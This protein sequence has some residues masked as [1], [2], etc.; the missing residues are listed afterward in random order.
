MLV[1]IYIYTKIYIYRYIC[2]DTGNGLCVRPLKMTGL[3]CKRALEKR[4]TL[5][6]RPIILRAY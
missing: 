3:F 1:N 2:C 4:H 5:L 6:K